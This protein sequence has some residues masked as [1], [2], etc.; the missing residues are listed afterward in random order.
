MGSIA[1]LLSATCLLG[2][3]NLQGE[4]GKNWAS[5]FRPTV[6]KPSQSYRGVHLLEAVALGFRIPSLGLAYLG[7]FVARA[8]SIGITLFI[9]L[10][11]NT[12]FISSG[13]CDE[14]ERDPVEMKEKC[15]SAYRLAAILTGVSQLVGLVFAPIFGFLAERYRRFNVFLLLAAFLGIVGYIALTMLRSPRSDGEDGT[16]WIFVIMALLG[17]S[18]IG[19]IVCSLGLLGR[20]VLGLRGDDRDERVRSSDSQSTAPQDSSWVDPEVDD[21]EGQESLPLLETKSSPRDL[22]HLKGSIAG[23]YSL[24]GGLGILLLTKVGGVL[25][26][27]SPAAPFLMLSVFNAL[28]LV[29][30][31]LCGL[32]TLWQRKEV[33]HSL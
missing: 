28:L 32:S 12:Y 29:V 15:R 4:E 11:V 25:F 31:V 8:S 21:Q 16:L 14:S 27:Q 10:F 3:R 1:F 33:L 13:L 30:G 18:Q 23:V 22:Q 5:L 2:L 19:A 9:P 7:G 17:I 6:D 20:C 26:D 24:S